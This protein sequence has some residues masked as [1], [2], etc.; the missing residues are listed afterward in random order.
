MVLDK[1]VQ[2]W[3]DWSRQNLP[4]RSEIPKLGSHD[5]T[6]PWLQDFATTVSTVAANRTDLTGCFMQFLTRN[7]VDLPARFTALH[8]YSAFAGLAPDYQET[9][10][11]HFLAETGLQPMSF[12][13]QSITRTMRFLRTFLKSEKT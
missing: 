2:P 12:G 1:R 10:E 13:L 3:I 4:S 5:A 9:I 6:P 8:V 11:D 7:P